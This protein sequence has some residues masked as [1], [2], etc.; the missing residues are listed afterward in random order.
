MR[1]PI[2]ALDVDGVLIDPTRRGAG[3][4][5]QELQVQLNIRPTGLRSFF[6]GEWP[7]VITGNT[8]VEEALG[9]WLGA[10]DHPCDV[11]DFLTCWFESDCCLNDEVIEAC[12]DWVGRGATAVLVTNQEHRRVAFLRERLQAHL[13]LSQV[14]YS[15]LLG[16]TKPD[17][18][19]FAA[20]DE[21][22]GVEDHHCR[23]VFID[24]LV[25]NISAARAHGW[26]AIQ[27]LPSG[28]S[29]RDDVEQALGL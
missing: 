7:A 25:E 15:A 2:L 21:H 22:L 9:R 28:G 11:E 13:P 24:D 16:F 5:S 18:M 4:W 1:P 27:Y 14:V 12:V 20:A 19:F 29:W 17:P 10:N 6:Q 26:T 8:P 23:V 3:P